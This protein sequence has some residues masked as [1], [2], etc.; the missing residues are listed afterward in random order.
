MVLV[1]E[2]VRLVPLT[3]VF[4]VTVPAQLL[5]VSVPLDPEHIETELTA[6]DGVEVTEI[7]PEAEATQPTPT[8]QVAV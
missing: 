5:A 8:V 6:I 1:G 2:A 4:H 3:P 7:V